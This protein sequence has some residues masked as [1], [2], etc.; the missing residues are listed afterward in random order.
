MH[1]INKVVDHLRNNDNEETKHQQTPLIAQPNGNDFSS[2]ENDSN[3][4]FTL[5]NFANDIL[6]YEQREFY[7]ENGFLVIKKLFND[8]EVKYFYNRFQYLIDNPKKCPPAMVI[9]RDVTQ[10]KFN[11]R[12]TTTKND[13]SGHV[14]KQD[15]KKI[16]KLQNWSREPGLW[17]YPTNPKIVSYIKAFCGDNIRAMHFMEINK[18]PDHGTLSSRHPLHQDQWYFPYGPSNY[19]VCSWTALQKITRSNGCLSVIPGTHRNHPGGKL[20]EHGYPQPWH[21]PVNKAYHGLLLSKNTTH[22]SGAGKFDEKAMEDGSYRINEIL[23]HRVHLEMEP[24]DTVFFHPLLFHAS[25]ANLTHHSR[26]SIS[27]HFAS[28]TMCKYQDFTNAKQKTIAD[29]VVEM[30]YKKTKQRIPFRA[31]WYGKS[32]QVCGKDGN[33]GDMKQAFQK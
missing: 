23:R 15:E 17:K 27:V 8:D 13:E 19:I 6:T 11:P 29:E 2:L 10:N 26:R 30:A 12:D 16:V 14:F 18:P 21:G 22:S 4:L 5:D 28:S 24:G 7:E 31:V 9:M 33:L 1:R 25:G 32:R 3:F 20:L